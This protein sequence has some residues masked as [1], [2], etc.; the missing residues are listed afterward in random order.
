MGRPGAALAWLSVRQPGARH[1]VANDEH[2]RLQGQLIGAVAFDQLNAQG[3]K[4]V[5][6]WRVN[7]RVATRY[8]VP[9]FAREGCQ[10]AHE[11]AADSQ[12]MYVH[13]AYFK[14]ARTQSETG[15]RLCQPE[16]TREIGL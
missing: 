6:H 2:V 5:A 1:H 12:N 13:A 11:G 14:D 7:A 8:F 16:N 3:A 10:A 15:Q 4:L 9:R